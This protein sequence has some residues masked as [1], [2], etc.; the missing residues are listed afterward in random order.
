[1]QKQLTIYGKR[2]II[3]LPTIIH[4][5]YVGIPEVPNHSKDDPGDLGTLDTTGKI[6]IPE[7]PVQ[8]T[9]QNPSIVTSEEQKNR[10]AF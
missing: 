8:I 2:I 6:D 1:M 5:I 7:T 4:I 10:T 9:K 3:I